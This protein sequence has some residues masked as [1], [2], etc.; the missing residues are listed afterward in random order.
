MKTI[1][2]PVREPFL[3]QQDGAFPGTRRPQEF[4]S[5][6]MLLY[7]LT[8]GLFTPSTGTSCS[9]LRAAESTVEFE[10]VRLTE[11]VAA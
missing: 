1:Q 8:G 4:R 9:S 5:L 6:V 11:T 2:S 7:R 3:Q 10:E